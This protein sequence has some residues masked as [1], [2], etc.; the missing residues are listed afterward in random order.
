M[1]LPGLLALHVVLEVAHN[2][3]KHMDKTIYT[4]SNFFEVILSQSW[5]IPSL[6]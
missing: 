4:N 6:L 5:Y 3:D 1:A 2:T